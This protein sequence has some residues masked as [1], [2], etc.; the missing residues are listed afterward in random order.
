MGFFPFPP[1][2]HKLQYISVTSG[3]TTLSM[4]TKYVCRGLISLYVDFDNNRTMWSTNLPV[5]ICRWGV[6]EKEPSFVHFFEG[7]TDQYKYLLGVIRDKF[8][9]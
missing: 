2:S 5:K 1:T 9:S 7:S 6:K 4:K 8:L 3:F